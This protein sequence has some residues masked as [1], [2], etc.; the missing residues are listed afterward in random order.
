MSKTNAPGSSRKA[1]LALLIMAALF[2]SMMLIYHLVVPKGTAGDKSITVE[3]VHSDGSSAVFPLSTD[4]AY[5][6]PALLE[7]GLAEGEDG[8][9]GLYILTADSETAD[10]GAQQWWCLTRG[11]ETVNTGVDLTPIADGE[12]YEL[13]LKTGYGAA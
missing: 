8:P 7:S 13:T 1:I 2:V 4:Q 5:L 3:I 11:G 9:Y 12:H 6:G 10:E